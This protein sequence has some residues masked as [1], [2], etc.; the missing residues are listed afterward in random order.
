MDQQLNTHAVLIENLGLIPAPMWQI[1]TSVTLI[2]GDLT[3]L[4]L[5]W[6]LHTH[7][8]YTCTHAHKTLICRKYVDLRPQSHMLYVWVGQHLPRPQHHSY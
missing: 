1:E 8:Q 5:L 2:P 6:I 7:T 4:W 3:L